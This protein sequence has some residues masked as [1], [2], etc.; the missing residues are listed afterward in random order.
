MN[1]LKQAEDSGVST[2]PMTEMVSYEPMN[3]ADFG[4]VRFQLLFRSTIPLFIE[5]GRSHLEAVLSN[6]AQVSASS[7]PYY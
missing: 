7:L 4:N 5:Q 3:V 1:L 2:I 6:Y